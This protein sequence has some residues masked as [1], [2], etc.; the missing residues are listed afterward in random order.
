VLDYRYAM[1]DAEGTEVPLRILSEAKNA[2][3][4]H[5]YTKIVNPTQF[6]VNRIES[7]KHPLTTPQ[8]K[9]PTQMAP[10]PIPKKSTYILPCKSDS[11]S[12]SRTPNI[13]NALNE[14]KMKHRQKS[15]EILPTSKFQ[16]M[17]IQNIP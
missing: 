13:L 2:V 10:T 5:I 17:T 1:T 8:L 9:T 4:F 6:L 15:T 16:R 12:K 14:L 3:E 7:V 11:I